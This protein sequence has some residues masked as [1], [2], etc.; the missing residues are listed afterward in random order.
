VW[1]PSVSKKILFKVKEILVSISC[2]CGRVVLLRHKTLCLSEKIL[3][4]QFGIL[5][6]LNLFFIFFIT[7]P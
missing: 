3:A 6:S 2:S 1:G 5:V 4:V 7:D